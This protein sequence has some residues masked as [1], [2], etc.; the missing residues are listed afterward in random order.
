MKG[1]SHTKSWSVSYTAISWPQGLSLKLRPRPRN[2]IL[3]KGIVWYWLS[4]ERTPAP[5]KFEESSGPPVTLCRLLCKT[6]RYIRG[7]VCELPGRQQSSRQRLSLHLQ[8]YISFGWPLSLCDPLNRC[9]TSSIIVPAGG[10]LSPGHSNPV[11]STEPSRYTPSKNTR[12]CTASTTS[13]RWAAVWG[14][15]RFKK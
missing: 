12:T 15:T 6:S 1:I 4:L 9:R 3:V 13:Y 5:G 8:F 14:W 2:W 11:K 10:R 7:L